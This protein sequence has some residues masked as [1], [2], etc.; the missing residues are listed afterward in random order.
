[1]GCEEDGTETLDSDQ[2]HSKSKLSLAFSIAFLIAFALM[3]I[4][5]LICAR[6]DHFTAF[7]CQLFCMWR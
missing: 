5:V 7:S 1:M 4:L 2:S 6:A 3:I